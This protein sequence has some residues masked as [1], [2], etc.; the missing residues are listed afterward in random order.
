[1]IKGYHQSIIRNSEQHFEAATIAAAAALR[2]L[3]HFERHRPGDERP[4][5]AIE[6]LQG[7]IVG[8]EVLGM[9]QVRQ[10]SLEAHAAAR[11]CSVQSARFAARSAGQAIATWHVPT[12]WTGATNYA[13]KVDRSSIATE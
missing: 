5:K 10:L 2:V 6:A 9:A 4:R 3:P 11:A 8:K 12:H 7:W 1:M 13:A